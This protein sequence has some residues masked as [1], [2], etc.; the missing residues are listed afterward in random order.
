MNYTYKLSRR[1]AASHDPMS[2][3]RRVMVLLLL[4]L[5]ISCRDGVTDPTEPPLLPNPSSATPGW[6]SVSLTT[7]NANDGAVQLSLAGGPIDSL[8]LSGRGFA[9]LINGAA[10]LLLTGEVQGGAIARIWVPD[11]RA[12]SL[13]QG[14]VEAAAAKHS[15]QLQDLTGYAVRVTR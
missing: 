13:Y 12:T 14:I 8:E 5:A 1:L 2:D 3:V 7:P 6:L 11:T 4:L 10:R 15:Y 9:S